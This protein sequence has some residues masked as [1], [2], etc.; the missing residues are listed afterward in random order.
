[1]NK[2]IYATVLSCF[3]ASFGFSQ[4][5]TKYRKIIENNSRDD[6]TQ[7][8]DENT[9]P[10]G[11][12]NFD[13][14]TDI[15]ML[16]FGDI[17]ARI[18]YFLSPSFESPDGLRILKDSTNNAYLLEVKRIANWKEVENRLSEK[19]PS[20]G[21]PGEIYFSTPENI[22]KLTREHNNAMYRK[23]EKERLKL[24]EVETQTFPICHRFAEA[25]YAGFVT[26]IEGFVMKGRPAMTG[27]GYSVTFRCIVDDDVW[28]LTIQNPR[29]ENILELSDLC[30]RIIEDA[31]A[32]R[33]DE[34][35]YINGMD[36][37][38]AFIMTE[39]FANLTN[40]D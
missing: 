20:I 24:Y 13:S 32:G 19:Y 7:T 37:T 9:I 10:H 3:I 16:F 36:W 12:Y 18:E 21:I 28:T 30:K 29:V 4:Q 15:E 14:K 27:D 26:S 35:K 39:L 6:C 31:E 11:S 25:L 22:R 40:M 23:R 5:S 8:D 34:S 38:C 17:N 2:I 33:F 1:M